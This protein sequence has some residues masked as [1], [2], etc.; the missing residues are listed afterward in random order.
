VIRPNLNLCR[1]FLMSRIFLAVVC[2][3]LALS[4]AACQNRSTDE[5]TSSGTGA[6]EVKAAA[7]ACSHCAGAQ[8][9]TASGTCP[10]CG[11]KVSKG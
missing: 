2:A 9:A 11:M 4:T 5:T 6:G 3:M 10:V 8:T 1:S 7:D